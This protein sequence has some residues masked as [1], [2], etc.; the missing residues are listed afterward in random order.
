MIVLFNMPGL[1]P[2]FF[3]F[4]LVSASARASGS[5]PFA[6]DAPLEGPAGPYA[7][8]LAKVARDWPRDDA[9][10]RP[11]AAGERVRL[12]CLETPGET[13][14]IGVEQVL[15]IDAPLSRV[16]EVLDA[17]NSY[18]ELF[19]GFKNVKEL[20]RDGN[21]VLT[22][23]EQIVP[24]FFLPNLKYEMTYLIDRSRTGYAFYRYQ[25]KSGK[26]LK[27]SDGLII[28][29]ADGA[30]STRYIEF[31]FFDGDWGLLKTFAPSKIWHEALEG[32]FLSD[33][34]IRIK[35]EHPDYDYGRIRKLAEDELKRSPMDEVLTHREAFPFASAASKQEISGK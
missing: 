29:Q 7:G 23:W 18:A 35:A 11:L 5:A 8:A 31:D 21:R 27:Y 34:A 2:I 17:F 25:L 19:H 15:R 9:R 26:S 14:A 22:H 3:V 30:E 32:L 10:L 1:L 6:I 28:L 13:N 4:V 12:R 16:T 33:V 20:S 24:V